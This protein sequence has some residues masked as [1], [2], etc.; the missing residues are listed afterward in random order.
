MKIFLIG[1][2]GTGKSTTGKL[3][4][5]HL[6]Y[7][8]FDIDQMVEERSKS[9]IADLV[10]NF[11]WDHFRQLEKKILFELADIQDAVIS[12]GGGVVTDGENIS[13]LKENG[14]S[15]WLDA[16]SDVILQRLLRDPS[17]L[18]SRPSLTEKNLNEEILELLEKRRPLYEKAALYRIQT[19]S[20]SPND[21]VALIKR[22]LF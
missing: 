21:V 13:F 5:T 9:K 6:K 4:A 3:L 19:D 11:G 8:F 14:L 16:G 20:L 7:N 18:T 12:T 2:R 15:I 22:R 10:N 17:S 1:Y